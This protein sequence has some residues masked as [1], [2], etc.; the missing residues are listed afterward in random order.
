MAPSPQCASLTNAEPENGK[1][2]SCVPHDIL[3]YG[4]HFKY[5]LLAPH[6]PF[7]PSVQLKTNNL[8]ILN[9]GDSLIALRIYYSCGGLYQ[10]QSSG[11]LSDFCNADPVWSCLCRLTLEGTDS[12]TPSCIIGESESNSCITDK[13]SVSLKNITPSEFDSN[14]PDSDSSKH[15][16][17]GCKNL[18]DISEADDSGPSLRHCKGF[19]S[20]SEDRTF[21]CG[22]NSSEHVSCYILGFSDNH[23]EL[24]QE[25]SSPFD[26]TRA[27]L[28]LRVTSYDGELLPQILEHRCPEHKGELQEL[29]NEDTSVKLFMKQMIFDAEQYIDLTLRSW[30]LIKDQYG[31]LQDYDMQIIEV[32]F[33]YTAIFCD[34]TC[35]VMFLTKMKFSN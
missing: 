8:I 29:L 1:T 27:A 12:W 3:S 25:S 5:D 32:S 31:S 18:R 16:L 17:V 28:P 14:D 26:C 22:A 23:T 15:V 7:L 20:V 2:E 10:C 35:P 4:I 34:H 9:S 24:A 33:V 13:N 6:P 19:K 21:E 30:D 11:H